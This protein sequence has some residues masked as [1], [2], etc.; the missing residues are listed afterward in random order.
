MIEPTSEWLTERYRDEIERAR[1]EPPERKMAEG[2]RL[3]DRAI[4]L[5]KA[6]IRMQFPDADE[7]KV[8]AI[9][10]ERLEIGRLESIQ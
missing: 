1:R 5:M 8:Q 9:L 7:Q 10:R 6:G 4:S 3:F 2:V